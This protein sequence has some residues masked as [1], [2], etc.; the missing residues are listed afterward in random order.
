MQNNEEPELIARS[1]DGDSEAYAELVDRYKNAVYYHCFA[2][3]R[4]EDAAADLAQE[5][6]ISAFYNIN[7]YDDTYRLSTWLFKISTNKCLNYIKKKRKEVT[8]DDSV[9]AAIVSN[10]PSSHTKALHA[11]LHEA[12]QKL[13]PK[14]RAVISLHYWQGLDYAATAAVMDAPINSVRVW[15]KRAKDALRK[16]LA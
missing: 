8:A 3:V 9:I 15:L 12:V 7:R 16:E 5:T 6:F 11:E 4:D 13:S 1:I 14:Y 10:E 2:V